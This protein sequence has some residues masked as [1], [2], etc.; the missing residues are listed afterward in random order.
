MYVH[1]NGLLSKYETYDVFCK[2]LFRVYVDLNFK[3]NLTVVQT[4][5]EKK[6]QYIDKILKLVGRYIIIYYGITL[7]TMYFETFALYLNNI[8]IKFNIL[9]YLYYY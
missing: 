8:N 6:L 9:Y 5:I 4:Y 1:R 2:M 7:E 3:H